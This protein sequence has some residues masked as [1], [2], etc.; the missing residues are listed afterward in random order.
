[1]VKTMRN[2]LAL[3]GL[4]AL[5]FAGVGWWQG[6][7]AV[8]SQPAAD[9]QRHLNIEVNTSKVGDDTARWGSKVVDLVE[10]AREHG[11]DKGEVKPASGEVKAPETPVRPDENLGPRLPER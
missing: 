8:R 4:L 1:M 10:K 5:V 2:L 6:W 3:L 9:G 11:G 7:Y